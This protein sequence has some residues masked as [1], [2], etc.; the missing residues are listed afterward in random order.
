[1]ATT[2]IPGTRKATQEMS[3]NEL[4]DRAVQQAVVAW[5]DMHG[6]AIIAKAAQ[7]S[8]NA[9]IM[10]YADQ[11]IPGLAEALQRKLREK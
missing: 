4:F 8:M 2:S 1:M 3:V 7:Q 5:L 6:D 11:I 9:W 10:L